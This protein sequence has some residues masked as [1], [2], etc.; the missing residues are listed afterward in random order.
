MQFWKF[1]MDRVLNH[2]KKTISSYEEIFSFLDVVHHL[3][4]NCPFLTNNEEAENDK[5]RCLNFP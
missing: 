2:R 3:G 4:K 1:W 5:K